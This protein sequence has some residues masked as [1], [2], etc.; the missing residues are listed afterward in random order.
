M[1]SILPI[2]PTNTTVL[3][4]NTLYPP[5]GGIGDMEL[6]TE[7]SA[8]VQPSLPIPLHPHTATLT[9]T[10]DV[11]NGVLH[12]DPYASVLPDSTVPNADAPSGEVTL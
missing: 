3:V 11:T 4:K 9:H 10:Q 5:S 12:S 8:L 6:F 2:V 1:T 7:H